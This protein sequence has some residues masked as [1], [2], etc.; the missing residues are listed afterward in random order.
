MAATTAGATAGSVGGN[1]GSNAATRDGD[2]L[3]S[4]VLAVRAGEGSGGRRGVVDVETREGSLMSTEL[5]RL[6]FCSITS[7]E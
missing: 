2:L 4:P 3:S 5:G 1:A 6:F 7:V